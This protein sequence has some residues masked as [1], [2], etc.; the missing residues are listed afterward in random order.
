VTRAAIPALQPSR[1]TV[2]HQPVDRGK[3]LPTLNVSPRCACYRI[4]LHLE[5]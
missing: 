4:Y 2:M 3:F 5:Q 1:L